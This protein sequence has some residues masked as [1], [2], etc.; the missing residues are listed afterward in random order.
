MPPYPARRKIEQQIAKLSFE[1]MIVFVDEAKTTQVWQW[2]KREVGKPVACREHT[3]L[4][5]QG[6]DPLL[7][8]LCKPS[9]LRWTRRK[10]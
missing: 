5:G 7:Q 4:A 8:R 1:H 3:F 9:P 6:G 10:D 2:V